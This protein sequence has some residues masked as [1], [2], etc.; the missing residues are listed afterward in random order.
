MMQRGTKSIKNSA[1]YKELQNLEAGRK[2]FE[3]ALDSRGVKK[4]TNGLSHTAVSS[5]GR[6]D[7]SSSNPHINIR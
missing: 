2:L 3:K 7:Q 5:F 4:K 6:T 1:E